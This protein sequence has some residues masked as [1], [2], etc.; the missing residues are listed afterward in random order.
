M[1]WMQVPGHSGFVGGGSVV[2]VVVVGAGVAV[3]RG[4]LNGGG[5]RLFG[6]WGAP[7]PPKSKGKNEEIKS[8]PPPPPEL[9]AGDWVSPV[10]GFLDG[11]WGVE[12]PPPPP[13]SDPNAGARM[14]N[15]AVAAWPAPA[16]PVAAVKSGPASWRRSSPGAGCEGRG[17]FLLGEGFLLGAGVVLGF[18]FSSSLDLQQTVPL[19]QSRLPLTMTP[20]TPDMAWGMQA[21]GHFSFFCSLA[22]LLVFLSTFSV[23]QHLPLPGHSPFGSILSHNMAKRP[24]TQVPLQLPPL[25]EEL[26]LGLLVV[27]RRGFGVV[28]VVVV[29]VVVFFFFLSSLSSPGMINSGGVLP[30]KICL[31]TQHLNSDLQRPS[32]SRMA[33]QKLDNRSATQTPGQFSIMYSKVSV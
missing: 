30:P 15:N 16:F 33:S 20:Q 9:G 4:C 18:F 7:P 31:A 26:F 11:F 12:P 25:L 24:L 19:E 3:G 8:N 14:G 2:V 23:M 22:L 1:D 21:P 29:L 6:L 10:A 32:M 13:R 28:V 5:F 27:V 17:R